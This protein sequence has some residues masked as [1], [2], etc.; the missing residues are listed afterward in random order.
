VKQ[1]IKSVRTGTRRSL[2]LL[3]AVIL[4]TGGMLPFMLGGSAN[5]AQLTNRSAAVTTARP[6]QTFN[7]T[8]SFRL[9]S[10]S[11]L[12]GMEFEFCDSPLGTCAV[13]QTPTIPAGSTVSQN[14]NWTDATAWGTYTRQAAR[15]GGAAN[16]QIRVER[17]SATS[18]TQS[19]TNDRTITFTGLTNFGTANVSY[20]PRIRVYSDNTAGAFTTLVHDGAVAQ[21][22]SQTLT[23]NARVQEILAFCIGSTTVNDATTSIVTD[24]STAT[25]TSVDLG[26][27]TSTAVSTTPVANANGGD[28]KNAYAM[29]LT[30]AQN[31]VT[32]GYQAVQDTSSGKL[33]VTGAACSGTSTTDQCF[34]SQ[35][36]TQGTFTAGTEKFGMTIAGVNCASVPAGSYTCT[37][38]SGLTNLQPLTNY[39]GGAYTNGTSG[40]YGVTQGFAW[41]DT[42]AALTTIASSASSAV[43]VVANEALVLRFAATAQITT[44]TGQYQAQADF[45]ATPTF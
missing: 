34:N 45:V 11:I 15:N 18:E 24:C 17:T 6:G 14:G 39:I 1:S 8:F 12:Q 9:P 41:V 36:G 42:G 38:A 16:T 5:A 7:I 22:T 35:G 2:V 20:Y 37:F 43:K 25:G 31:G 3:Q 13:T 30:N 21:S 23:V 33:K 10:S 27:V 40:T 4:A 19:G 32:I 28:L 26:V 44:P 29:V